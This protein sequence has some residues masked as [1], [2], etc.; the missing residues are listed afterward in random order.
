MIKRAG[1]L[2]VCFLAAASCVI[3]IPVEEG[4]PPAG[5]EMITYPEDRPLDTSYFYD[6]LSAYGVWVY[7]SPYGYVWVPDR[8]DYEWRPYSRGRWVWTDYGWTWISDFRW[9]WVPFHY[10]RWGWDG[11]IGWYWVPDTIWAPAWVAWRWGSIYVGWA[12]L[13]PEARFVPGRGV[14][15]LPYGLDDGLWVFVET[16]HFLD[17]RL[18][19]FVLPPE[20]NR[21]IIRFTV[22]R[23]GISARGNRI[24]NAGISVDE[25][26]RVVRRRISKYSLTP[27]GRPGPTKVRGDTVEIFNPEVTENR[28]A[29]P[30]VVKERTEVGERI[31]GT[32][33][34]SPRVKT[35]A[36]EEER[37]RKAQEEERRLLEE[38]QRKELE[39]LEKELE[40]EKK[41]AAS[42]AEKQKIEK[43]YR[44]QITRIKKEHQ[45]E[46]TELEK[47]HR[48]ESGQ[49]KKKV[50]KK[51]IKR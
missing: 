51:E 3:Y 13:P 6:Y 35:P 4:Y 10:G 20:R 41:K 33:L 34:R 1:I 18:H 36:G 8:V 40:E 27:S 32:T 38:S 45:Q 16:I 15:S 23:T 48:K 9:G 39:H 50:K 14:R 37:L 22:V 2:F 25:V 5:E 44:E 21:T 47:R 30:K 31:T 17:S 28:G 26:S 11:Y 42:P 43:E 49:A 29:R 24:L 12:P 7:H 46:K 19:R